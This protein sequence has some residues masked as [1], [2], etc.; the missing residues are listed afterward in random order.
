[1]TGGLESL[2][3]QA[4]GVAC[5]Q[6]R[7]LIYE[8][9]SRVSLGY[10]VH[11]LLGH[12]A[13]HNEEFAKAELFESFDYPIDGWDAVYLKTNF[14]HVHPAHPRA[15]TTSEDHDSCVSGDTATGIGRGSGIL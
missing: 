8:G 4:S 5:S 10:G 9:N 11:Y 2:G 1:M 13:D 15:F 7:G 3:S 6:L 12:G 14:G